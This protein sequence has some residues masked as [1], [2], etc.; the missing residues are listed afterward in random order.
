MARN[1]KDGAHSTYKN[2]TEEIQRILERNQNEK[3][4]RKLLTRAIIL[5]KLMK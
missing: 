1:Q 5:E 3:F 2:L 4:L